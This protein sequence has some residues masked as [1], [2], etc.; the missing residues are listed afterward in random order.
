MI[1]SE[2]YRIFM[3]AA[4]T[5]NLTK[6]GQLLHMTQ[7]SVS[8]AIKQLEEALGII[9]FDRLSKG[10]RLTPE[11]E[12][13]FEHVK[14][15]FA[16]LERAEQHVQELKQFKDG[17]IR[18]GANGAITKNILLPRLDQFHADYPQIRIK[19]VQDKTSLIIKQMKQ[20]VI[21]IGFVHL[22]L[23][24]NE[25]DIRQI[26]PLKNCFVVGKRY[27]ELASQTISAEQLL[28]IPLLML[29]A[30]SSTRSF[31]EHWFNN[32]G[33][34][35]KADI[36][37]N[38][39]EMLAAFAERGYGAAFIPKSFVIDKLADGSL[40]ELTT[41]VPLPDRELGIATRKDTSLSLPTARFLELFQ[42]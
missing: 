41:A 40:I 1:H 37:L 29:S 7:P 33:Y 10:V 28:E 21:D 30:G 17:Q 16:Q 35:A 42:N 19:L 8:Y 4:Q 11:G 39:L 22:P 2:W 23:Q 3:F 24:D 31:V 13:L 5:N 20:G 32:Q 38:S 27:L 6:A 15:A 9:L 25:L 14:L 12:Q 34:A 36:E 18:I 26:A